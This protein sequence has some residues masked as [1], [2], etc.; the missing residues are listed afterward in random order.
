MVRREEPVSFLGEGV[1]DK[2]VGSIVGSLVLLV[3]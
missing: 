2:K 3:S 1:Q